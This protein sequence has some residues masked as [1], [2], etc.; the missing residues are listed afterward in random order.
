MRTKLFLAFLLVIVIAL[1]SNLIFERLIMKDFDDYVRGT[2][3]DHLYWVLASVEGSYNNGKWDRNSLSESIHWGMML[4][5]D[6]RVEDSK[7]HELMNSI[8]VMESLPPAMKRRMESMIHLHAAEGGYEEYP[9]YAG[10]SELGTLL[11]RR[12]GSA[13]TL[14]V[15]EGIFKE[16]GLNFLKI[17]FLIA[18]SGALIIAV[19]LSLYLS[20][21]LKR[22]K[23]AAEKVAK[24]DFSVRVRPA[25]G[26]EIG[27]VSES[28]NYMADALQ[29][30]DLLR[31]RLASNIAHELRTPLAIMEAQIEAMIDG[32]IDRSP[33]GLEKIRSEIIGLAKLVEG[34]EDIA[35]AE[36]SFFTKGEQRLINLREFLRGLEYAMGPAFSEKGLN[37]SVT[38]RGNINVITDTE[39]LDRVL[40]NL[41]SNAVKFTDEGGA[42]L[43]YGN[44]GD[45]FFVEVKDTGKGIHEDD[46]SKIFVR[47]YRGR[48]AKDNGIGI[49]LSIV[50]ELVDVMGGRINAESKAG[51]G[52][53][54]RVWLPTK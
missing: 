22:L 35:K 7:G 33:E 27:K 42:L 10:G 16:R 12:L 32:V 41:L 48:N 24:G 18:G 11:V 53:R 20:N 51:E 25:S 14:K 15:K 1:V 37:L 17:S 8:S 26:D 4:G 40:R 29:K 45:G 50:K 5:F 21:P 31:K 39:K 9:L 19:L 54:F 34:I 52:S 43:D 6:L 44:E 49:G 2:K 13:G 38:D 47:F 3:E 28:F 46:L 30:E 36:A 23:S